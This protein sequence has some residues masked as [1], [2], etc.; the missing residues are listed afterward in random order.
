MSWLAKLNLIPNF[1][2]V[3]GSK[4]HACV[5]SKQPRKPHKAAKAR[6]LATLELIHTDLSEMNGVD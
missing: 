6:N 3:R 1:E 4:F 5:Q 2:L